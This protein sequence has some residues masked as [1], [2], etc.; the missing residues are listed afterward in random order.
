MDL[1]IVWERE[2]GGVSITIPVPQARREGETDEQFAERIRQKD[3]PTGRS[4]HVSR[5][6]DLPQS[7]R[8]RN[9]WRRSGNAVVVDLP[10]GREIILAEVR[11]ERNRRLTESDADKAKL[12]DIGTPP[13][14]ASLQ[15]YRQ[16]LRDLPAIVTGEIAGLNANQLETYQPV[17]PTM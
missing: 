6:S 8:L 5:R 4:Y 9:A 3:I 7:R 13:E 2:D 1:C 10:L 14:R 15:L 16:K 11:V 17:W 12:D